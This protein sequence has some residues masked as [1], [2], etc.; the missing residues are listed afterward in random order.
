ME[1]FLVY[2][3]KF[4]KVDKAIVCYKSP[5]KRKKGVVFVQVVIA[6]LFLDVESQKFLVQ[7][8]LMAVNIRLYIQIWLLI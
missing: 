5:S 4:Y 8:F 2:I 7:E 3:L 6:N 1:N